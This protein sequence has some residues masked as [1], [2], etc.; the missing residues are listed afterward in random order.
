MPT[1]GENQSW[2]VNLFI[3]IIDMLTDAY[4]SRFMSNASL[5][6]HFKIVS[7]MISKSHFEN[8]LCKS[9][10]GTPPKHFQLQASCCKY[11]TPL[12]NNNKP[13]VHSH[14]HICRENITERTDLGQSHYQQF[15]RT[16]YQKS[17]TVPPT[18][19]LHKSEAAVAAVISFRQSEV[20]RCSKANW[21]E[22][23]IPS[24]ASNEHTN[25]MLPKYTHTN[26]HRK[27]L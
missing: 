15:H 19:L 1:D 23:C 22:S 18:Q 17:S 27:H 20:I 6:E 13:G 7:H 25:C 2:S 16:K 9:R 8:L 4:I 24:A 12:A 3:R 14:T 10:N 26:T 5:K 11:K 21:C